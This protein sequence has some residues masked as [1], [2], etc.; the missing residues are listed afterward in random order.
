M[1]LLAS[2]V[3]GVTIR[4]ND[5]AVEPAV[6]TAKYTLKY[7]APKQPNGET[8]IVEFEAPFDHQGH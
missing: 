7:G 4:S 8:P 3:E 1:M 2:S 5:G 6:V